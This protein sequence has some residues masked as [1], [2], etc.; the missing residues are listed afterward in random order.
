[1]ADLALWI[2]ARRLVMDPSL[3]KS[4]EGGG[5]EVS[6]GGGSGIRETRLELA[7]DLQVEEGEGGGPTL[8]SMD[9]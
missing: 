8:G 2:D 4:C 1:M 6:E 7:G 3:G 5:D 9:L